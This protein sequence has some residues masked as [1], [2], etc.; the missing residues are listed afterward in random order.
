MNRNFW[1]VVTFCCFIFSYSYGSQGGQPDVNRQKAYLE[2]ILKVIDLK[3]H[4]Y[5][6]A[7]RVTYQDSTWLDWLHR[8]GELPPDFSQMRSMPFLPEPLVINKGGQDIPIKTKEQWQEKREWIKKEFQH[9]VSG[10][11]PP[12]PKSFESKILSDRTEEGT[13]IQ[14]IE[15]QFGPENKARMTIEL[16]IPEGKGPFPVYMSQWSQRDWVQLAVR[17]GYIGCVYAAADN[18]DDTQAYQSLYPDYDFSHLMRRAWG[19]SRVVDYL[20]TRKEVNK[21][22]IAITGHSRNGK[23]SLWAAAFDDR[24]SAVVSASGGTG[25][26]TPWRYSDPQYTSGTLDAICAF[27]PQWFHPRLRFFFGR[28]DKLPI[29]Q[30]LLISLIAPRILLLHY[31]VMELELNPWA[32]EQ[33]YQSVKKVYSFLGAEQNVGILPRPGEHELSTRDVERCI[34]YLDNHFKRAHIPWAEK[35]YFDYSYNQWAKSHKADSIEAK[36]IKP[37]TITPKGFGTLSGFLSIKKEILNNLQWI[38]GEEPSGVKPGRIVLSGQ[39]DW[40]NQITGHPQVKGAKYQY[41]SPYNAMGDYLRG[42]IYYPVD[43]KG[44]R[45]LPA[46]GKMPVVIYLHQYAYNH[47]FA[48]GYRLP[49]NGNPQNGSLFQALIDKGFAVMAIDMCGFGTRLDEG[50]FFYD[51]FPTWSKMGMMVSDVKACVDALNTFNFIDNRNIFILGNTIGGSVG[52]MAAAEDERI[53]GLA[54]LSSVTPWRTSN[55]T[56]ESIRTYSQQHL[57]TPRLGFYAKHPQ[58][59]PVDFAEIISCIAPRPVL[60]IAPSLDRYADKTAVENV[61]NNVQNVYKLYGKENQLDFQQPLEINR[62]NNEMISETVD[63]FLSHLNI[64]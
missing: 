4:G 14:M 31:S 19:A 62:L 45:K 37:V 18:K 38:L 48:K 39:S 59:T 42:M 6:T 23:Q 51:R 58:D 56:Y 15:M 30:N 11:V 57:F 25:A 63:F 3:Q 54:V 49:A 1:L 46:N 9:W 34:D 21:N 8:S 53:A 29:D 61:M 35:H 5:S 28:E 13:H 64:N 12:A 17:R 33:C 47:G 10:T 55:S 43:E 2:E 22:Q 36:N 32:N 50:R 16:M 26:I 27:N 7:R 24:I 60:V 40:I 52:F 44:N 20:M 41:I